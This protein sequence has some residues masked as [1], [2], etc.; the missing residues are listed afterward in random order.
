MTNKVDPDV[1]FD[2]PPLPPIQSV[3]SLDVLKKLAPAAR[4]LSALDQVSRLLPNQY[5]LA[6]L[7]PILESQSSSQIEN[8]VTTTDELFKYVDDTAG[9]SGSVK[10]ILRY[11]KAL[12][13]GLDTITGDNARPLTANTAIEVCASLT[14]VKGGVRKVSGTNLKNARTG[15]VIYTPPVGEGVIN[16]KLANWDKY[17]HN[18]DVDPLIAMAVLHYQ[19]EA[20]HPFLDG[21]GRTGRIMNILFLVEKDLLSKPVLYLSKFILENKDEYYAKL[22]AVTQDGDWEA[23]VSFMLDAVKVTSQW[24]IEKVNA[25][26]SL[27]ADTVAYVKKVMPQEYSHE[28]IDALFQNPYIR[29]K[30][31]L[32]SN[33]VKSRQTGMKY[34]RA[35]VEAGVLKEMAHGKEVLFIHE[36]L[37]FLMTHDVNDYEGFLDL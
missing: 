15:E 33:I 31:V 35:L 12:F 3:E 25:V 21:N 2:V 20:I 30:N 34:L 29:V 19:F 9:A 7:I 24:T 16:H 14:G 18:N 13:I 17:L 8:I 22:R 10:E 5:L 23:W 6:N 4:S 37:L 36:R 27:Q 28:L 11:K 26:V 1:P 32:E